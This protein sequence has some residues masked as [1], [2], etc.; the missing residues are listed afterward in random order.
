MTDRL[1]PATPIFA[2]STVGGFWS[3]GYSSLAENATRG[4]FAEYLVGMALGALDVPRQEWDAF[5]LRYG[6]VAVE[7]KSSADDQVWDQAAPSVIRFGVGRKRWWNARTIEWSSTPE[8]PADVYV[9]CHFTGPAE[10]TA[11]VNEAHWHF[12]V[13]PTPVLDEQLGE[14][15]SLGLNRL[16]ELTDPCSWRLLRSAVDAAVLTLDR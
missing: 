1:D 5:D 4:V 13:V 7:V 8:R 14:Q 10:N 2:E 12:Y 15:K 11:I 3:W 6:D 16:K 9:F